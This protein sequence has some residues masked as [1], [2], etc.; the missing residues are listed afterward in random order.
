MA[1]ITLQMRILSI[2][3]ISFLLASTSL[4][5]IKIT[6]IGASIGTGSI[7][8]NSPNVSALSGSISSDF[9]LWF[10]DAVS[11][12]AGFSHARMSDYFLPENRNNKYYPFLNYYTLKCVIYQPLFKKL[13]LEETA[14]ILLLNDRTFVDTNVWEFGGTFSLLAGLD[15]RDIDLKG[16]TIGIS[17]NYGVTVNSTSAG[18]SNFAFNLNYYF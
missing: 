4:A 14:G 15:F 17:I 2:F 16:F 11:F 6:N 18:Y 9:K 12:R 7:K 8:G 13:Y 5:Q 10:S 1:G 3:F